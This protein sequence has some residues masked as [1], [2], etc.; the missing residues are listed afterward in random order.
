MMAVPK[1]KIFKKY[2]KFKMFTLRQKY[3][4]LIIRNDDKICK[5]IKNFDII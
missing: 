2:K 1:K 5:I 3:M 4:N